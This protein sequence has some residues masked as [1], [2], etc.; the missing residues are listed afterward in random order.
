MTAM[1]SSQNSHGLFCSI[2]KQQDSTSDIPV[3]KLTNFF[4]EESIKC[5]LLNQNCTD[6]RI[7]DLMANMKIEIPPRDPAIKITDKEEASGSFAKG[8]YIND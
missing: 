2:L 1:V 7:Q 5:K 4:S 6:L 3:V 8:D